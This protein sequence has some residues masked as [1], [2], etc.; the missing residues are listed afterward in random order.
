MIRM[1]VAVI[2]AVAIVMMIGQDVQSW[3]LIRD[4]TRAISRAFTPVVRTLTNPKRYPRAVVRR[5]SRILSGKRSDEAEVDAAFAAATADDM[6]TADEISELLGLEGQELIDF[7]AE[8][9]INGNGQID[10]GE[11]IAQKAQ[12]D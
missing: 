5:W 10:L 9:D 4:A 2:L 3:R 8:A 11:F 6:L 1:K 12:D 7:I